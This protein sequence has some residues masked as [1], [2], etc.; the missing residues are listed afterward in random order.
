MHEGF[1]GTAAPFYADLVLLLEVAMGLALLGGALL[2]RLGQFRAHAWLQSVVVLL[3]AAVIALGMLPSFRY[4]VA[5]KIPLK[6]GKL[7]F[8]LA[9]AHAALGALVEGAALYILLAAGTTLVPERIRLMRY[10]LWMRAVLA[11]WWAVLLLG[12][13]TYARWYIPNLSRQ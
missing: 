6:L 8:G 10:K 3:N 13:A 12:M 7:F 2:A 11:G 4:Q 1:I 5:P 9:T